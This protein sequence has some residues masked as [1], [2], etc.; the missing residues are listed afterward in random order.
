MLLLMTVINDI[1]FSVTSY[2]VTSSGLLAVFTDVSWF[3]VYWNAI[4][5]LFNARLCV[6]DSLHVMVVAVCVAILK[7]GF[8]FSASCNDV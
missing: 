2:R 4:V 3:D 5:I 6:A 8:V 1:N 7:L